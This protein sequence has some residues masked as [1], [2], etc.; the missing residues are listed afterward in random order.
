MS[1]IWNGPTPYDAMITAFDAMPPPLGQT[2]GHIGIAIVLREGY[3]AAMD[4]EIVRAW[5]EALTG[6][7]RTPEQQRRTNAAIAAYE[8]GLK[9]EA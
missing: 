1:K 2:L 3:R 8:A 9:E 7:S 5:Y 4:G 6:N